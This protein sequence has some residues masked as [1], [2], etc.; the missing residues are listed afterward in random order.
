MHS[1][2]TIDLLRDRFNVRP[3][4]LSLVALCALAVLVWTSGVLLRESYS[5]LS[6][7]YQSLV[8]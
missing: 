5:G 2:T 3:Y 6:W 1:V 4:A 7:A 8:W